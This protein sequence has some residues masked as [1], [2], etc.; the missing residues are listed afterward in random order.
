MT[1]NVK[2]R[3][4]KDATVEVTYNAITITT[5][6]ASE[7]YHFSAVEEFNHALDDLKCEQPEA[8]DDVDFIHFYSD[9]EDNTIFNFHSDVEDS[10]GYLDILEQIVLKFLRQHTIDTGDGSDV[11]FDRNYDNGCLVDECTGVV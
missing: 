3:N 10:I 7:S 11:E 1:Y 2:L 4:K 9:I 8:W 6:E 5:E